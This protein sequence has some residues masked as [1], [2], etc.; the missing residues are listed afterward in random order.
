M[1]ESLGSQLKL[2]SILRGFLVLFFASFSPLTED[3]YMVYNS[4]KDRFMQDINAGVMCKA[5]YI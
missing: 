4:L 5:G 2:E 3:K 1:G